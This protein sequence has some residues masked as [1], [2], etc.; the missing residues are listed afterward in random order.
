M[1]N[2]CVK[3]RPAGGGSTTNSQL[4]GFQERIITRLALR[5]LL[6]TKGGVGSSQQDFQ[7]PLN[8]FLRRVISWLIVVKFQH[9]GFPNRFITS[10]F[11]AMEGV[12][13]GTWKWIESVYL[14]FMFFWTKFLVHVWVGFKWPINTFS[15]TMEWRVVFVFL[16]ILPYLS[17]L[18][19]DLSGFGGAWVTCLF[20]L[21]CWL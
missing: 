5:Q 9:W 4:G 11:W 20:F 12:P 10:K 17:S 13:S 16:N 7:M 14:K 18:L 15:Q 1:H 6:A 3:S 8:A 21:A 19:C 2:T